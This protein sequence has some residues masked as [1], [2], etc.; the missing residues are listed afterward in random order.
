MKN[1]WIALTAL[2]L[3]TSFLT[4]CATAPSTTTEEMKDRKKSSMYAR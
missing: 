2:V 1:K 3:F 4:S